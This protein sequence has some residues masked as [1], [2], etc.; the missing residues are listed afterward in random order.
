MEQEKI[1]CSFVLFL[2]RQ[3][4]INYQYVLVMCL[5][6]SK[7]NSFFPVWLFC[8][9]PY[10]SFSVSFDIKENELICAIHLKHQLLH[11]MTGAKIC[12]WTVTQLLEHVQVKT[13]TVHRD[14]ESALLLHLLA[15]RQTHTHH[16]QCKYCELNSLSHLHANCFIN[17]W[18]VWVHLLH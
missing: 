12:E 11:S 17:T 5:L 14:D 4:W 10:I 15:Q 18:R 3:L 9:N 1:R 2:F 6:F 13:T 7:F 8:S 16:M